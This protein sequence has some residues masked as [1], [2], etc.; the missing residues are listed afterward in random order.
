MGMEEDMASKKKKRRV[1]RYKKRH[2]LN[3]GVIIFVLI[4]IYIIFYVGSYFARDKISIYEVVEGKSAIM[5]NHS[6]NGFA[7]RSETVVGAE[8]SGYVN[9][10]VK[11]GMRV[12][13]TSTVYTLDESGTLAKLLENTS[14]EENENLSAENQKQINDEI[15]HFVSQYDNVNFSNVYEFKYDLDKLLLECINI[16]K[17]NSL[18]AGLG[19]SGNNFQ[20]KGSPVSGVVEFYTDGYENITLNDISQELFD[21]KEN[22][23]KSNIVSGSLVEQNSPLFKVINSEDWYII[24]PLSEK[25]LENYS[26]DTYVDV[27]FLKD[28]ITTTAGIEIINSG[29]KYYGKLSFQRYMLR[30]SEYRYLDIQILGQDLKGLKIPKTA[31]TEKSF[32]T[33]P[34]EY[35]TKGGDSSEDGFNKETYDENGNQFIQFVTP[36]IYMTDETYCYID[37]SELKPGDVLVK[38]DSNSKFQ[39]GTS[40]ANLKGVYNVNN[41]YTEFRRAEILG[42]SNEYYIIKPGTPFG[43]QI[44]DHIVLDASLV[45]ENQIV[46][47]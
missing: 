43:V 28:N 42:E 31:V 35:I 44:Y 7:I 25:E 46:F 9:F 36:S 37:E 38:T 40:S 34:K 29:E 1:V 30:Y 15:G 16:N 26:Q 33:I 47:Q 39:L 20:I 41:G 22:Y 10:Y 8:S 24:I 14:D 11:N 21:N 6:Y 3:I 5:A 17:L 45:K 27:R 12:S 2:S 4:F 19:E 32:L 23:S 18:N 13:K